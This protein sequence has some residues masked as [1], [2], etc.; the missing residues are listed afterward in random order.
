FQTATSANSYS[1][2]NPPPSGSEFDCPALSF[3]MVQANNNWV[4]QIGGGSSPSSSH[5]R[6][7][8]PAESDRDSNR[9]ATGQYTP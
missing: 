2:G 9:T 6:P 4:A 5:R 3:T 7:A 8:Q 1:Y